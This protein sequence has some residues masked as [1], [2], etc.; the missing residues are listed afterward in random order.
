MHIGITSFVFETDNSLFGYRLVISHL[1]HGV[2]QRVQI[3]DDLCHRRSQLIEL[4]PQMQ[5]KYI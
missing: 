4:Y 3:G 2:L 1:T 5:H